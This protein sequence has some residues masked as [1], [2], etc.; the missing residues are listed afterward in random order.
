MRKSRCVVIVASAIGLAGALA[1][2]PASGQSASANAAGQTDQPPAPTQRAPRETRK[3]PPPST[4]RLWSLW[5]SAAS[6]FESN[7]DRNQDNNDAGGMVAGAGV[8]YRNRADRPS[9]VAQYQ[10]GAHM[11][12]GAPRWDRISHN[13]R[14]AFERRLVK[15][16]TF[17]MVGE[18]SIKGSTEDRELGN[19]YILSPRLQYRLPRGLRLAIEGG[20]RLKHYADTTRNAHNPYGGVRFMQRFGRGRWDLAYRYEENH[21]DGERNRYI[22]STYGGDIV[23]P[24]ARQ[25]SIGFELKFRSRRYERLVRTAT[26]RVPLRDAKWSVSPEWVHIIN[27]R[28]QL[29]ASYEF[30]TR[31]AN[32]PGRNYDAHS[33]VLAVERRW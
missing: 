1:A 6:V 4:G 17:E 27:P 21:A 3:A 2:S 29:R 26:G 31:D 32:D 20:S 9:L 8:Q 22:R 10:A 28:L 18:V 7:I 11:Y 15:P 33:T 14:L 13:A 5:T 30:E 25:D 19:Q 24:V 16:L 12:A 23:V